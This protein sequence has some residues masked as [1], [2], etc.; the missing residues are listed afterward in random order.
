MGMGANRYFFQETLDNIDTFSVMTIVSFMFLAPTAIF[1][2]G[3][4]FTPSYLQSAV[5]DISES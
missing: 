2:E 4:K 1:V 3:F 5:S